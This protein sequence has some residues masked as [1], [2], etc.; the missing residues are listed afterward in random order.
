[1]SEE[2]AKIIDKAKK[3]KELADRGVGGEK[4]NAK[5]MYEAYKKKHNLTDEDVKGHEYTE[6]FKK[7]FSKMTDEEL[8]EVIG[9]GLIIL[10]VGLLF[11]FL[12]NIVGDGSKKSRAKRNSENAKR[13]NEI[14]KILS[15]MKNKNKNKKKSKPK[16]NNDDEDIPT[17]TEEQKNIQDEIERQLKN[18]N[19][20]GA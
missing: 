8:L 7:N 4:E 20:N 11:S 1:M 16:N 18:D 10:G 13:A 19:N 9:K 3:L 5:R 6:D 12:S 14:N 15:Q 2:R 17:S